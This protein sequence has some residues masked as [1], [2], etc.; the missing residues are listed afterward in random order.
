MTTAGSQQTAVHEAAYREAFLPGASESLPMRWR[1][2]DE[3]VR[4]TDAAATAEEAV[5]IV[6]DAQT[7]LHQEL[8]DLRNR[9]RW[10]TDMAQ[11]L[12]RRLARLAAS[13]GQDRL[14]QGT[15]ALSALWDAVT[16][17]LDTSRLVSWPVLLCRIPGTPP[18]PMPLPLTRLDLMVRTATGIEAR[19]ALVLPPVL[20]TL[21]TANRHPSATRWALGELAALAREIR[22]RLRHAAG[23]AARCPSSAAERRLMGVLTAVPPKR[24]ALPTRFEPPALQMSDALMGLYEP[25]AAAL[26]R[27]PALRCLN[28]QQLS[29]LHQARRMG[30]EVRVSC[31]A[32]SA[33]AQQCRTTLTALAHARVALKDLA[34]TLAA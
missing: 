14:P 6:V 10:T 8:P 9:H 4:L 1:P 21:A 33:S 7:R 5:R 12:A 13:C 23:H 26:V 32:R 15:P 31:A 24:G 22:L 25:G 18:G 11:A 2:L 20:R 17:R 28:A 29:L 34:A 16:G 30:R 19:A 27:E 3:L